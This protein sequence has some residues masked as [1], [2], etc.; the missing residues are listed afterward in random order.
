M[1]QGM[2]TVRFMGLMGNNM[3]Q[4]AAVKHAADSAGLAFGAVAAAER[5]HFGEANG[6]P[7]L[8]LHT[9]FEDTSYLYSPHG[10][11]ESS[12]RDYFHPDMSGSFGYS[13]VPLMPWVRYAGYF[14]SPRYFSREWATDTFRV[15]PSLLGAARERHSLGEGRVLAVHCRFGGDRLLP[16][17]IPYHSVVSAEYYRRAIDLVRE[18]NG[19]DF[20]VLVVS[21]LRDEE[22]LRSMFG[23]MHHTVGVAANHGMAD[24]FATMVQAD[25][26]VIGNSTFSWWAAH[27]NPREGT[28][29]APATEWFGPANSHLTTKDLFPDGWKLL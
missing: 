26:N 3:F 24:A 21:D 15:K 10:F 29:V 4:V 13:T 7:E 22:A 11:P 2:V 8:E 28:V 14:Q 1:A 12:F 5:G 23:G 6:A 18:A 16:G 9:V 20:R 19:D 27:L 17:T 25:F